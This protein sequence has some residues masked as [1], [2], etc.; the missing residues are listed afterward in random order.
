MST[1]APDDW[2][3]SA[4]VW[5][6]D[7]DLVTNV[8][9]AITAF[10]DP[11]GG[12]V[13]ITS[14]NHGCLANM[15]VRITGTTHYDGEYQ[16]AN[17]GTNTFRITHSWDGDDAT[18]QW[19]TCKSAD[20][21]ILFE[22]TTPAGDPYI[23]L[24]TGKEIAIE[25]GMAYSVA[26]VA[27]ADA[28]AAGDS[29]TV[30]A[31]WHDAAKTYMSSSDVATGLLLDAA[32]AWQTIS[33]VVTAPAGA[34]WASPYCKKNNVAFHAALDMLGMSKM[35][36]CFSA[37]LSAAQD[38][39]DTETIVFDTENFDYGGGFDTATGVYTAS[40]PGVYMI[41]AQAR[42]NDVDAGE[43]VYLAL[44][45]N[46]TPARVST[47]PYST[48]ADDPVF[49]SGSWP[50]WLDVGDTVEISGHHNHVDDGGILVVSGVAVPM[51]YTSFSGY[52]V[53]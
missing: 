13:Q 41:S 32:G 6:T 44:D 26:A 5:G 18:G 9:G 10:T 7:A 49:V 42:F 28:I 43:Y 37:Y 35:P 27:E 53:E 19:H 40:V 51:Q 8:V 12:Q 36:V 20:A 25:E 3:L 45:Q 1:Y 31:R 50:I 23:R 11:G 24:K 17:I 33:G 22:D 47:S 16:A 52:K 38:V 29:I 15:Y 4:G 48:T 39:S 21:F 34:R 14:V 46:G 30:G 2:V